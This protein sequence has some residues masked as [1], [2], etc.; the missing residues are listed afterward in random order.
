MIVVKNKTVGDKK[1]YVVILGIEYLSLNSQVK[2]CGRINNKQH[3]QLNHSSGFDK[4]IF[5]EVK[6]T[7]SLNQH[8]NS[9][10][11]KS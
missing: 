3:F 9:L 10:K 8:C 7:C 1:F 4:Y 11:N 6:H 5:L 2:Y